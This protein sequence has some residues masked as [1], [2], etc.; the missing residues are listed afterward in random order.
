[1]LRGVYTMVS[2]RGDDKGCL[3]MVLN[4]G[5]GEGDGGGNVG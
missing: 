5:G 3:C 2:N 4:S 1:M